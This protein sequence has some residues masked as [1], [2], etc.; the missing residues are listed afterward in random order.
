MDLLLHQTL[1][2]Q[3]YRCSSCVLMFINFSASQL[4]STS[5][6]VAVT[7]RPRLLL[8][9]SSSFSSWWQLILT[10]LGQLILTHTLTRAA[11]TVNR[12]VY[13]GMLS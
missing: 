4:L 10:L 2:A 9:F 3:T 13:D 5:S 12:D 8:L 11:P 6:E 7:N 1:S